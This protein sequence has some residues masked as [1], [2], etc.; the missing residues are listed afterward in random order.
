MFTFSLILFA[1]V[2]LTLC[3]AAVRDMRYIDEMIEIVDTREEAND[4]PRSASPGKG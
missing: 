2:L 4:A 3:I 1:T